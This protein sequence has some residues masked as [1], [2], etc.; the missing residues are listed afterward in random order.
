MAGAPNRAG[1]TRP[2]EQRGVPSS[3]RIVRLFVGQSYGFIRGKEGGEIFFHRGDVQEGTSFNDFEVGD[4]VLF[5]L[6]EDAV[7]GSRALRVRRR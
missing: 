6:L 2:A 4:A 5:E 7:S 3:G 1:N